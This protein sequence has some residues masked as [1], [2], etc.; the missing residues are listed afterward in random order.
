MK[1]VEYLK[2]QC[3]NCLSKNHVV[4]E[5]W[6]AGVVKTRVHECKVCG[7]VFKTQEHIDQV[8]VVK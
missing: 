8:R 5:V 2:T 4:K 3:P 6:K 1:I 7:L